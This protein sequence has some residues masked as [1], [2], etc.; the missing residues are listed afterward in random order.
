MKSKHKQKEGG[1]Q[2][3]RKWRLPN[4]KNN[5]NPFIYMVVHEK[6]VKYIAPVC[7]TL[8]TSGKREIMSWSSDALPPSLSLAREY[9]SK[10]S[11]L[12]VPA[13]PKSS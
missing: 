10:H 7:H 1:L 12:V 4:T 2:S 11:P 9:R 6:S 3:G 8:P 5:K 13:E